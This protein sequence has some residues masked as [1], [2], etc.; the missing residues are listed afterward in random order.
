MVCSHL[1]LFFSCSRFFDVDASSLLLASVVPSCQKIIFGC[2]ERGGG[3][4]G[5]ARTQLAALRWV[6][7][8]GVRGLSIHAALKQ[9]TKEQQKAFL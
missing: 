2:G 8:V 6:Q 3:P 9:S 7:L 4:C 1:A 5:P